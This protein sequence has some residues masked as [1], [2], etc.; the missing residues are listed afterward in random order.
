M[1]ARFSILLK[2]RASLTCFRACFAP[3][4]A[5]DL[6]APLVFLRSQ[7]IFAKFLLAFFYILQRFH[8]EMCLFFL[9][10][11]STCDFPINLDVYAKYW[12]HP[13]PVC[14]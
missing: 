2:S 13:V 7:L 3:G 11:V 4:R 8:M 1:T 6:S 10:C 9:L 12:A 5:K 14:L